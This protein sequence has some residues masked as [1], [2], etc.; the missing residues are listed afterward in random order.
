MS[1]TRKDPVHDQLYSF[2]PEY[3]VLYAQYVVMLLGLCQSKNRG[4]LSDGPQVNMSNEGI[5]QALFSF[6]FS[7][8][9]EGP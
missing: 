9:W 4:V 5:T 2:T 1:K 3:D 6:S 8:F 7:L